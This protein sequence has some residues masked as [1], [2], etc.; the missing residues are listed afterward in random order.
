[1]NGRRERRLEMG[2]GSR[3]TNMKHCEMPLEGTLGESTSGTQQK[4][5]EW[6]S[7]GVHGQRLTQS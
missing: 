6:M 3:K 2:L 4:Q 5:A 7:V 1:M